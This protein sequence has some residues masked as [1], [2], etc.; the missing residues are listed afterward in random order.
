MHKGTIS[1]IF[2]L[3][4]W[5]SAYDYENSQ[6]WK[7]LYLVAIKANCTNILWYSNLKN[8]CGDHSKWI[9]CWWHN[10]MVI[11]IDAN[12]NWA[13]FIH[14]SEWNENSENWQ[15]FD[16]MRCI[17]TICFLF[18]YSSKRSRSHNTLNWNIEI[19]FF[20]SLYK[21]KTKSPLFVMWSPKWENGNSAVTIKKCENL[22]FVRLLL[23][24]FCFVFFLSFFLNVCHKQC[25]SCHHHRR[26]HCGFNASCD[27][28]W[29]KNGQNEKCFSNLNWL[30]TELS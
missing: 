3:V 28:K 16:S 29:T 1:V 27:T 30:L 11:V 9:K 18:I 24:L 26:L 6:L 4:C 15:F 13:I 25:T 23:R 10:F 22:F 21:K 17:N 20:F 5:T 7:L 14:I 19:S 2:L 8:I 12:T